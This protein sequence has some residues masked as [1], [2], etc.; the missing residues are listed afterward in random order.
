MGATWTGLRWH[1]DTGFELRCELCARARQSCWWPLTGE[2]WYLDRGFSRCRGCWNDYYKAY[3]RGQHRA[4]VRQ[5]PTEV[6]QKEA[7]RRAYKRDWQRKRRARE[8][9]A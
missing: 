2:F 7:A 6:A 3:R 5:M 4:I 8:T 1:E 9:A